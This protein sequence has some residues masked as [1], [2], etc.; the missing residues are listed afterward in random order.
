M[1]RLVVALWLP[2]GGVAFAGTAAPPASF[3]WIG[4]VAKLASKAGQ[5][6]KAAG[7]ASKGATA[8]KASA[9]LKGASHLGAL[10]A[11]ERVLAHVAD[12]AARVPLFVSKADDGLHLVI[13]GEEVVHDAA[14]LRRVV[15]DLDAMASGSDGAGIDVYL[16]A[17]ALES[18]HDLALGP[19]VRLFLADV[20]GPSVPLRLEGGVAA[21]SPARGVWLDVGSTLADA[22]LEVATSDLV[23]PP[24]VFGCEGAPAPSAGDLDGQ[25]YVVLDGLSDAERAEW[26]QYA[27]AHG[28]DLVVLGLSGVCEGGQLTPA[29]VAARQQAL[30]ATTH[31]ALWSLAAPSDADVDGAARVMQL[32]DG[33]RLVT[34]GLEVRHATSSAE[35]TRAML[36][37]TAFFGAVSLLTVGGLVVARRRRG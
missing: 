36:L 32:K 31:A 12:D 13:A 34:G 29:G 7:A 19:R 9:A 26:E 5:A 24:E 18:A 17:S 14:G 8:A 28:V 22:V 23:R 25:V 37:T 33:F 10:V 6:S 30:A 16:D 21:V 3:G 27:D 1:R 11:A 15:D 20:D 2:V 35:T 4:A